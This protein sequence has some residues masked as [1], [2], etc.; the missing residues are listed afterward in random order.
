MALT[1]I[2]YILCTFLLLDMSQHGVPVGW[3]RGP[4]PQ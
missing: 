3:K 1:F 2:L 4:W